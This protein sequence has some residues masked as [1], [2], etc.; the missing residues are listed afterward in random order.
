MKITSHK[1]GTYSLTD[2]TSDD[3]HR[4]ALA[5][6]EAELAW[7]K[8]NQNWDGAKEWY[9]Q[10]AGE[11]IRLERWL[12]VATNYSDRDHLPRGRS[13][14]VKS[15]RYNVDEAYTAVDDSAVRPSTILQELAAEELDR[16]R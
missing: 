4:L 8:T 1:N 2:L 10:I 3:L 6:G 16:V 11:A 14:T 12:R 5:L 9:A 7:R 13:I 15:A